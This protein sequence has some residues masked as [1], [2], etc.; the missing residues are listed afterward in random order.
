[1]GQ[2]AL[3]RQIDQATKKLACLCKQASTRGNERY[4][5]KLLK[6]RGCKRV[7][8]AFAKHSHPVAPDA[9]RFMRA[10]RARARSAVAACC[11]D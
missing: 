10:R 4:L 8:Q 3:W 11:G 9:L 5:G 7:G 6:L 1:M 2:G